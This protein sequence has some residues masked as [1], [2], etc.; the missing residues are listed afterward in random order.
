[1]SMR[2]LRV[3]ERRDGPLYKLL[4]QSRDQ[5]ETIMFEAG[6]IAAL[7]PIE[8]EELKKHL[9]FTKILDAFGCLGVLQIDRI[10]QYLVMVTSCVSIGKI[11]ESDIY[12]ITGTSCISLRGGDDERAGGVQK[13][14]N[15][16]T[17]YFAMSSAGSQFNL[18]LCSQRRLQDHE[19]DNRFFWN[20]S[21]H[22]QFER[23]G[24]ACEKWLLKCMCGG[25]EIRTVYSGAKQAKACL[26][27]RHSCERAGTRYNTRGIND[28]GQAANF[29]ETEQ[30]IVVDEVISSF[31]Q[32]RGSVPLFWEQPG[33]NVGSHK[34]K[35]SRGYEACAPALERH[36]NGLQQHY[37]QV[38]LVNLLGRKE[39]EHSL[40]TMFK[41][42]LHASMV[43]RGIP[44]YH[45][46]YHSECRGGN[47]KNLSKLLTKMENDMD[48]FGIFHY[49]GSSVI[50]QQKGCI[51]T[52]CVDCLDRTNAV[53]RFFALYML[54]KQLEALGLS[55]KPQFVSR[56]EEIYKQIWPLNGDHIS[57][58]YAGTG[59]MT[60]GK[61]VYRDVTTSATRAI[62]NNFLDSSKQDAINT[63]LLGSTKR[64]VLDDVAYTLN[65]TNSMHASTS[66][67]ESLALTRQ[68]Y[69]CTEDIRVC[70]A[71]WNVNGGTFFRSIAFRDESLADWLLDVYSNSLKT[72]PE[73]CDLSG[74]PGVGTDIFAI[75]FEEIVDLNAKN[76]TSAS[77]SNQKTWG[78][79]LE[80]TLSRDHKYILL[81]S[82][83][84][85]G[86][87]LFVFVRPHLA[88]VIR[89]VAVDSVK[90]GLGGAAGNKGAVA[91]RFMLYN[92]SLCFVCAHFTAGQSGVKERNNDFAEICN[93][94]SFPM[95][96]TLKSHEYVFW[97][98]DFNY[99]IDMSKSEVEMLVKSGN[100]SALQAADQL[101]NQKRDG[102]V[103]PDYKEGIPNFAPTYKYDAFCDDYDTS[104]KARVPSW[105]D[106]C[107]W[108]RNKLIAWD[109]AKW[110]PGRL[111]VYNRAELKTSDHRPVAALLELPILKVD[112]TLKDRVQDLVVQKEGPTDGTVIV[113][114]SDKHDITDVNANMI[115]DMFGTLGEIILVRFVEAEI[116]ITYSSG[117]SALQAVERF[118]NFQ[119]EQQSIT[120]RLS[121][122]VWLANV[123]NE[124]RTD[125]SKEATFYS[126]VTNDLL[127]EDFKPQRSM[128]F[129]ESDGEEDLVE[130]DDNSTAY[131]DPLGLALETS[132]STST[133]SGRNTPDSLLD[134]PIGKSIPPARPSKPPTRPPPPKKSAS[135][136]DLLT[137][138]PPTSEPPPTS[139]YTSED[140][141]RAKN[142]VFDTFETKPISTEPLAHSISPL[143]PVTMRRET[144]SSI[145]KSRMASVIGSPTNVSHSG[146]KNEEDAR[147][148][149]DAFMMG[150]S[151]ES[152]DLPVPLLPPCDINPGST[153]AI[154]NTTPD[155]PPP[156]NTQ[157][158]PTPEDVTIAHQSSTQTE[159]TTKQIKSPP[160]PARPKDL[161]VANH[162]L[163]NGRSPRELEASVD[164]SSF[165]KGPSSGPSLSLDGKES[166]PKPKKAPPPIP[167]RYS[168][169]NVQVKDVTQTGVLHCIPATNDL[170][171]SLERNGVAVTKSSK[172]SPPPIP[173]RAE[174]MKSQM[175]P[176]RPPIPQ[177]RML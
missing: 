84:L 4:L 120:V 140:P 118:N 72:A 14:L 122:D 87:C 22:I 80:K 27:S 75:G 161:N 76:I 35:M 55:S 39:G 49:D 23:Y 143:Q 148:L 142:S 105:T 107:L 1:M 81:T 67:T 47:S 111:L 167:M 63:L 18:T 52:N 168:E 115:L 146:A 77:T 144:A 9:P 89:D 24:I 38:S 90:T 56:F 59:A 166:S 130:M 83:Q 145:P 127:G 117:K 46:D 163:D 153:S 138:S 171:D 170:P 58:I 154:D 16:G 177:R 94:I 147:K 123:K 164:S 53:Q 66:L 32:I 108:K 155:E 176:T 159:G 36:L 149:I 106:R 173:S 21:M 74:D 151:I 136:G 174:E 156:P 112:K 141:T 131:L 98:G 48:S 88:P 60:V 137:G 64:N 62:Q 134:I 15:S 133:A 119:L 29:V 139:S 3:H 45:F 70:L 116:F 33:L 95:G 158:F 30:V 57:R 6:A 41:N 169:T 100:W 31:V 20:R 99:R 50:Q 13:L 101:A 102:N 54:K 7:T 61:N 85:V 71:T 82:V 150:Q 132:S 28:D 65:L 172:P 86:V 165:V 93:K 25:I 2:A 69:T 43:C 51:R 12:K 5:E 114:S 26:I 34:V 135:I 128:S 121:M 8:V 92:S 104:E 129:I 96:A 42:H 152:T 40:T 44:Y 19:T 125:T 11:Q 157:L 175:K 68:D 79:E 110:H 10:Y 97:V 162:N 78:M 17:F 160:I 103:F 126:P 113:A 91:I 109:E 73:T 37:G 124:L